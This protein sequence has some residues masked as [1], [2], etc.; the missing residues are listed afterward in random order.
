MWRQVGT[1]SGKLVEE[2]LETG[3]RTDMPLDIESGI[4]LR[5][6]ELFVNCCLD[7]SVC[8]AVIG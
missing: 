2:Y 6:D 5:L 1:Q 7:G 4:A 3:E 8:G